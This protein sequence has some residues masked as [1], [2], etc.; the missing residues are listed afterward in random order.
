MVDYMLPESARELPR[1]LRADAAHVAA[2]AAA[3]GAAGFVAH[4]P[5]MDARV[6]ADAHLQTDRA[7]WGAWAAAFAAAA[8][9]A[10]VR[11]TC[12]SPPAWA[13]MAQNTSA[14]HFEVVYGGAG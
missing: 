12:V 2:A 10:P 1:V 11:M 14:A 6:A 5:M 3:C 8:T 4:P 13:P 7:G 9:P